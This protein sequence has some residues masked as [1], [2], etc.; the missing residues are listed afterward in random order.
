[1]RKGGKEEKRRASH[2]R[3]QWE[4]QTAGRDECSRHSE[5]PDLIWNAISKKEEDR[6]RDDG[7]SV[8]CA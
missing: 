2:Q 8:R 4:P 3:K 5:E 7:S 1:M 6:C